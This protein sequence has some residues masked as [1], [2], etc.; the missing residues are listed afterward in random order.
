MHLEI[1]HRFDLF[2][3]EDIYIYIWN[4]FGPTVGPV[5]Y[6]VWQ[7]FYCQFF[8]LVFVQRYMPNFFES[9]RFRSIPNLKSV[10]PSMSRGDY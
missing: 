6:V 5:L 10:R 7:G 3:F 9:K 1:W 8:L 2:E 4:S